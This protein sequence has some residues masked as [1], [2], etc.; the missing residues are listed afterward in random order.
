MERPN[1]LLIIADQLNP[2][3][4]GYAGHPLVKTPNIDRLAEESL[5]FSRMYSSQP[6]CMPARASMFTGMNP[7]GHRVRMNGI[8]L[9]PAV[10]TFT[11][12]LADA[13]YRTHCAGKIHLCSSGNPPGLE[14]DGL[15]PEDFPENRMLWLNGSIKQLPSPFYGLQSVD[16]CNGHGAGSYGHY[17]HWLTEN[18]PEQAG[19]FFEQVK[20]E[21]PSPAADFFNRN[22][23]KWTLP[24]ELHPMSWIT[25]RTID[26]LNQTAREYEKKRDQ[27]QPFMLMYSIQE[28]HP[29]F[30]PP[31]PYCY[32]YRPEEIPDVP[33]TP[34]EFDNLPPH[35][36]DMYT[37]SITTSGHKNQPMSATDPYRKECTAHYLGLISMIDDKVGRVLNTLKKTGLDNSTVIMFISDHGQALG[38]HGMW[39]KGPYHFDS[40]I[41][42]PF[43]ISWPKKFVTG[44][45][46]EE[47]V[48]M[49]D[50]A[51]TILDIAGVPIPEGNI[52]KVAE[53]PQAPPAWPGKSLLPLLEGK[54]FKSDNQT[55]VEMDE[56]YLG[57]KMRT[58]VTKRYRLTAYSGQSYGELFDLQDDPGELNNLWDNP[59]YQVLRD[60]LRLAL[61]DKIMRTDISL[62]RQMSRA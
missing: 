45:V 31:T 6:L 41:R 57:F 21:D 11:Q 13:G 58:L 32:Q 15:K 62:P 20:L 5:V 42:V 26:F 28:P 19:L 51:P 17:I 9:D 35:F 25:E 55:L 52:P 61:L 36:R 12:A 34:D 22:S 30:A 33:F 23:Y 1:F 38:D 3:C 27:A 44:R 4:L 2:S 48:E 24:E 43:L 50:F 8:D 46:Y 56:D 47:P 10:P 49:V 18:Y 39:G 60:E 53:A 29:P 59:E 14:I 40:V 16:Y 7:R 37:T 54:E